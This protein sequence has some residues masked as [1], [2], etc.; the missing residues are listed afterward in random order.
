VTNEDLKIAQSESFPN[1][2]NLSGEIPGLN[3]KEEQELNERLEHLG[4]K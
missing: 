1:V 2:E 4:Y 3:E